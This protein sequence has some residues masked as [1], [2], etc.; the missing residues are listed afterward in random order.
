MFHKNL[1][2]GRA[3]DQLGALL[4]SVKRDDIRRGM[5]LCKP[6]SLTS[7]TK[8]KAQVGTRRGEKLY[9]AGHQCR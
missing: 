4:R 9:S 7:H 3:G 2:E 5:V 8:F 6:G 1:D